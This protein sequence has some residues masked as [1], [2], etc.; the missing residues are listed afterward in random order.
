MVGDMDKNGADKHGYYSTKKSVLN[1]IYC[2][3]IRREFLELLHV[4]NVLHRK[5]K[6]KPESLISFTQRA[7]ESKDTLDLV[8]LCIFA[9]LA[10]LRE[11]KI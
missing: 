11:K 10:S 3:K 5:T 1:F 8:I 6:A 4:S 2:K 7:Q 9:F